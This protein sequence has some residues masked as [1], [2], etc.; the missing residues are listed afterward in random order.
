MPSAHRFDEQS[1][2]RVICKPSGFEGMVDAAFNMI[3]QNYHSVAA[4]SIH[5]LKPIRY[6]NLF[7]NRTCKVRLALVS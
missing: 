2:L 7:R 5:L 1:R 6:D 3:R 4:V